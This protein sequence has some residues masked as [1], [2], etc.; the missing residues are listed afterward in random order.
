MVKAANASV[1][2]LLRDWRA[3]RHV[4]Q[5][6]LAGEAEI[7]TRHLSFVECGRSVPS[8]ALLLKLAEALNLP[9]R[10]QN[11]LLLAAGYAPLYQAQGL[12]AP[13]MVQARSTIDAILAGHEPFPAL[14]VDRHW[15]LVTANQSLHLMLAQM[16]SQ[17]LSPPVN[18][19][20]LSLSPDG[21]APW[22]LNLPEWRHHLLGR[23]RREA[24]ISGDADLQTLYAELRAIAGPILLRPPEVTLGIAI[25]LR[26]RSPQSGNALSFLSTTTVFGT[27]TD[28]TLSE[29]TLECFYPAD[30]PTRAELLR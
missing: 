6:A 22:I 16:L 28:I 14:A 1:G 11:R 17:P 29:L 30:E 26:I 2:A 3:R 18:V 25:P 5:M 19:L 12:D 27:A 20:R 13:A 7:S 9:P 21:L 10:E 15:N 8:R 24:D 4:S 23:L